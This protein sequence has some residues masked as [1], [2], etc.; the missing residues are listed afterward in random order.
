MQELVWYLSAALFVLHV[1][2]VN[3]IIYLVFPL[4]LPV[5]MVYV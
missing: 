4:S 2:T 3:V 1:F 5:Y